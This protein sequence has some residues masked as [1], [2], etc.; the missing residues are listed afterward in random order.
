MVEAE[1][2]TQLV[3]DGL[4]DAIDGFVE[5]PGR[6]I[7]AEVGSG[8]GE[9]AHVR[10]ATRS[11]CSNVIGRDDHPHAPAGRHGRVAGGIRGH[12]DTERPVVLLHPVPHLDDLGIGQR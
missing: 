12:I 8:A 10:N 9:T 5:D 4:R 6:N 3:R 7:S 2:V 11:G 1:R